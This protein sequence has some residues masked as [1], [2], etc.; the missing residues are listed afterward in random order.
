MFFFVE[1]AIDV[2][3]VITVDNVVVATAD[4]LVLLAAVDGKDNVVDGVGGL[5]L[6]VYIEVA[7]GVGRCCRC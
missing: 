2:A 6:V 1:V 7:D 5:V 4:D 3:H